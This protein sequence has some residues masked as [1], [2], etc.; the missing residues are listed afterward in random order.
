[1]RKIRSVSCNRLEPRRGVYVGGM[2]PL[3][4]IRNQNRLN[5]REVNFGLSGG[6]KNSWHEKYRNSAWI[7]IGGLP[8]GLNEGDVLSVFS[9]FICR[10]LQHFAPS[11]LKHQYGEIVNINLI[12]DRKTGKS[13]GFAFIC[14]EDQRSTILAVDNF[15]GINLLKRTIRVDHVEQYKVPKYN[16]DVDEEI[17]RVWEE[18]CAPKPVIS[19]G[20]YLL[21]KKTFFIFSLPEAWEVEAWFCTLGLILRSFG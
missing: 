2:N 3:T 18:G 14:Y 20:S 4:N 17:R 19:Q 5:E 6:N 13:R 7:Y 12:R 10:S 16:E 11:Y 1:L 8:Y 9:Q 15:N 21:S